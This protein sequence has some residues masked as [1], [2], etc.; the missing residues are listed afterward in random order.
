VGLRTAAEIVRGDPG[1]VVL[2]V[3]VELASLHFQ[4]HSNGVSPE[5]R[6]SD[7]RAHA[8]FADGAAAAVVTRGGA[9]DAPAGASAVRLERAESL[10]LPDSEADMSWE[11]GATGFRMGLTSRVPDLL[12]AALPAFVDRLGGGPASLWAIHPGGPVIL[13]RIAETLG[14][15]EG[16]ISPSRDVLRRIGNVSSATVFFVFRELI[17]RGAA[18]PGVAMA[19]GPGL[20][21]EG[22]RFT[23][24]PASGA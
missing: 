6:D 16:A 1:A 18:G 7:L 12:A 4:Q 21:A 8:L 17:A 23:I 5:K 24:D 13:D 9:G 22:I 19:F 10:L 14:L 15:A 20:T 3:S 2:V 11:I